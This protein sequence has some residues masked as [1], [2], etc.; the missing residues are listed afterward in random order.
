ML[1]GQ[2]VARLLERA[3][4][5]R[6]PARSPS[7]AAACGT[8]SSVVH[9]GLHRRL[10]RGDLLGVLLREVG[11]VL[12]AAEVPEL[13]DAAIAV[14]RCAKRRGVLQRRQLGVTVVDARDLERVLVTRVVHVPLVEQLREEAVGLLA[15][16]CELGWGKRIG[17]HSA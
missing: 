11:E 6:G 9:L 14:D 8:R 2:L 17:R 13:P 16:G 7:P 5:C 1:L 4:R 15:D 10:Q 3:P 12:Q